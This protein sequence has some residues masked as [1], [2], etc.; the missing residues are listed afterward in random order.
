MQEAVKQYTTQLKIA[1]IP[2]S[3]QHRHD[4]KDMQCGEYRTEE[5]PRFTLS[6]A[7]ADL[8]YERS[9]AEDGV[10]QAELEFTAVCRKFAT[11]AA[12]DGYILFHACAVEAEG[13]A[14]LFAAP[15]GTG[16]STHAGLWMQCFKERVRILNGDKPMLGFQ[17]GTLFAHGTPF[18]GKE[19]WG[20]PGCVPVGGIC[21]LHRSEE[22]TIR[23][24]APSQALPQMLQQA[25]RPEEPQLA[26]QVVE[27]VIRMVQSVPVYELACDISQ[28][29]AELSYHTM[30]GHKEGEV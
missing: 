24:I 12:K 16:K 17:Q 3:V 4:F 19:Q 29:A 22:N 21:F 11:E 10:T 6:V 14:Y 20:Y 28:R 13:K 30:V 15:S 7:E 9:F 23:R 1:G 5:E 27:A 2:F 18:M 26:R 25:F 8:A